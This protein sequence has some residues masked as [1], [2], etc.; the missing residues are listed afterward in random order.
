MSST[1]R[2]SAAI[3]A[4]FLAACAGGKDTKTDSAATA[5]AVGVT[6]RDSAATVSATDA[7]TTGSI[8]TAGGMLDPNAA[9]KEQLV[10]LPGMTPAAADA[11]IAGRPYADMTA[12]DK[13]LAAQVKD[14]KAVYAHVWKPIDINKA[15]K[16]E[17]KLIPGV[18][19]K[20]AHEFEEYRPWKSVDQFRRE[21]GK[22]VDKAEVARL[23][24]YVSIPK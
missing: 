20:M 10:A 1:F 2:S 8:A 3:T 14:R 12:A 11:L 21:I 13:A 7:A 16:D 9:T 15:S 6:P 24:Q 5:A 23:E 17:M 22:Y 18:G 19:D 4:L